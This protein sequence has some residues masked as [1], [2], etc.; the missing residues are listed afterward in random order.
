MSNT[1]FCYLERLF[2][3][4]KIKKIVSLQKSNAV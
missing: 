1:P 2:L 3:N 4:R